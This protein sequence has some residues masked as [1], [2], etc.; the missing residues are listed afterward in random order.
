MELFANDIQN[1][2]PRQTLDIDK[3]GV[4]NIEYPISVM[5]K[6]KQVQ[7]TIAQVSMYVNLPGILRG[8]HMSRF[9]SILNK[10]RGLITQQILK[11][12]LHE[13]METLEAKSSHIE[14]RFPY[15][16]EKPA[17][18][19]GNKSIMNYHCG[20][21]ARMTSEQDFDQYFEVHVPVLNL[22]PCS[23]EISR[24]GAHN[25]RSIVTVRICSK[26]LVWMEDIVELVEESASSP[27]YSLLKREDE[28]YITEHSYE[29][30]RFVE[31]VVREIAYRLNRL[32]RLNWYEVESEN[33]ESI[34][35]HNV[36]AYIRKQF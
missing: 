15:F 23:K 35:N 20:F 5:D 2:T 36:Y 11:S 12:I 17:P 14:I 24:V 7:P 9:F 6:T 31:D 18:V 27:L 8:T 16:I 19:S 33:F 32:P 21:F 28:K 30:P 29:K 1:E 10:H 3:V 25:Q 4:R 34:H 13:M 26:R 22:C